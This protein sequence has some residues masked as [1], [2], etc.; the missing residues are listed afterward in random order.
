MVVG[1]KEHFKTLSQIRII[2]A[3]AVQEGLAGRRARQLE[4]GAE[5][6]LHVAR[7]GGHGS[8]LREDTPIGAG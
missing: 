2:G 7:V 4:S 6:F 8:C 3:F 1:L 5:E